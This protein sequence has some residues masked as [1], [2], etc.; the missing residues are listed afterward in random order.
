MTDQEKVW[1]RE[2]EQD[3]AEDAK[4]FNKPAHRG[5]MQGIIAKYSGLGHFVYE[6]LQNADDARASEASFELYHDRLIFRHNGTIHFSVTSL[7]SEHDD[8]SKI[9]HLN[10]ITGSGGFSTKILQNETGNAIGKFG[11]GF[12]A[13]FQYTLTPEIY[14][15]N[16]RF[17]IESYIVPRLIATDHPTRKVGE[18]LFV[19]PFNKPD[20]EKSCGEIWKALNSLVYPTLF[21]NQLKRV[22]VSLVGLDGVREEGEYFVDY[23]SVVL[24]DDLAMEIR[25]VETVKHIGARS[26]DRFWLFTR[27][28]GQHKFSVGYSVGDDG[29]VKPIDRAAFCFF[30][31]RHDTKLKFIIHAPFKLTDNREG[32]LAG[33]AHNESMIENLAELAANGLEYLCRLSEKENHNIVTDDI[34][35]IIPISREDYGDGISFE[36]FR[37]AFRKL[38]QN[39]AVL[40]AKNGYV[41]R[42]H[43]AWP[44]SIFVPRLFSDDQLQALYGVKGARWVFPTIPQEN[45]WRNV[46]KELT[47]DVFEFI[48]NCADGY[49][50][51]NNII[52]HINAE[53]IESQTMEWREKLYDWI[54]ANDQRVRKARTAP[55]FL[56]Q[57]GRACA[58]NTED[59]AIQLYLP[60]EGEDRYDMVRADLLENEHARRLLDKYKLKEPDRRDWIQKVLTQKLPNASVT[61]IDGFLSQIF[62]Y[63]VSCGEDER[64]RIVEQLKVINCWKATVGDDSTYRAGELYVESDMLHAYFDRIGST[65]YIDMQRYLAMVDSSYAKDILTL[66][67]RMGVAELP[68]FQNKLLESGEAF[69]LSIE[70]SAEIPYSTRP[71]KYIEPQIDGLRQFLTK[72]AAESDANCAKDKSLHLWKLLGQIAIAKAEE[73]KSADVVQCFVRAMYGAY[74]YFYYNPGSKPFISRDY[75]ILRKVKWLVSSDGALVSPEEAV[76]DGLDS[77]YR[78]LADYQV[79]CKMLKIPDNSIVAHETQLEQAARASLSD[80]A[81]DELALG[82]QAKRLGLDLKDLEEMARI[83]ASK[84]IEGMPIDVPTTPSTP[85]PDHP[86]EPPN[87]TEVTGAL[88]CMKAAV[89]KVVEKSRTYKEK[90]QKHQGGEAQ[91][92]KSVLPAVDSDPLQPKVIDFEKQ[93][94]ELRKK[95]EVQIDQLKVKSELQETAVEAEEYS[96]AWLMARLELEMRESGVDDEKQREASVSF[97]KMERE[98]GTENMFIL[99]ASSDSIPQWFE[100][101]VNQ[102]LTIRIPGRPVIETVIES[103][104]VMSFR[105]RAKVCILP[106]ME[107]I[108]Y[109]KVVEA[110]TVATKPTFLLNALKEG[111]VNLNL[112]ADYNLKT[113]L[114]EQIRFIFGPPGTGKT[115]YLARKELIPLA[116]SE[117]HPHVLVLTPTNKAADVLTKRIITEC[118]ED[119]S[120]KQWLTRF[121]ITLDP[122]LQGSPVARAKAVDIDATNPA[123]VVTTVIRFAYD[124]FTSMNKEKLADF[125]WDY[126]VIDEASMIPLMQIL[127]PI[128]KAHSS[129]FVIAGDPMQIAPVVMSDLS[130]GQNIYTM[131]GLEDFANPTTEPHDY[132][133]VRLDEQF[134]SIPCIGRIFSE[135]AYSGML[136][137]HRA[138]AEERDLDVVIDGMPPIK[139][140]TLLRY[141]VSRFE[142]IFKSKYLGGSSYQ[143]YS[144]LFV[145]EYICKLAEGLRGAGRTDFRIGVISPY[146]AQADIVGRLVT[147]VARTMLDGIEVNVG[148][149]H[150]FQGDECEMIIALLNPPHGMGYHP[151]SFINDRKVLNVAIS[152]ARDYLV[153][154]IPDEKAQNVQYLRGP[155]AI[156]GLMRQTPG[157]FTELQ[158]PDLELS[159]WGDRDYIEKNT[160]STGHQNVNVYETPEKR[161]EVR[162]E[163]TAVD[164]HFRA[165]RSDVAPNDGFV[166]GRSLIEDEATAEEAER[167]NFVVP[168]G[169]HKPTDG[170]RVPAMKQYYVIGNADPLECESE[171]EDIDPSQVLAIED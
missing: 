16:M 133:V 69:K 25:L 18:T 44:E 170:E 87:V 49:V 144:A 101:E 108:D 171:A 77:A 83:K 53:F 23:K 79:I 157:V 8:Q 161:F 98:P 120:Y 60:L 97:A 82:E 146:R 47:A 163:G 112:S 37:E 63:Y 115:T 9:G 68:R 84:T 85:R 116:K 154:A 11:V 145:F 152:R 67:I 3:R 142:S 86:E 12:K 90:K 76:S 127:Y 4:V 81:K 169:F 139:P 17:R 136:R 66:F 75:E 118:G 22:K 74:K 7:A 126:I 35:K 149:V 104:S 132:K 65:K 138:S 107:N 130:V 100:E 57:D 141:P 52:D 155:L 131:V 28:T 150:S 34:V 70:R 99:S 27:R 51:D 72:I 106:G 40:P 94:E 125:K 41:D 122:A 19:F 24:C 140:L 20:R 46:G 166:S 45:R 92:A 119:E 15:D 78:E 156:A 13:V 153:V 89:K 32:I 91:T 117:E 38:F 134:R 128:Y 21:L 58:V 88:E 110:K 42:P 159:V 30:P 129:K 109:S 95:I 31:T 151:G 2:I 143:I 6:L 64:G 113:N 48:D 162:S 167:A 160:F 50:S 147:K 93:A 29:I 137:H 61:E 114:P 135:F 36:P 111:Y 71:I 33:S 39:S 168:A 121:G 165:D 56:N 123:V 96:Y 158:T 14:D 164:V 26:T 62:G 54:A 148:T 102:R 55:I 73:S 103:M 5:Y 80:A 124:A 1:F 105:L 10:A 59:G 43:A